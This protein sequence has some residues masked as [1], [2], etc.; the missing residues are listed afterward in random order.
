MENKG[1]K[2]LKKVLILG[3]VIAS[4]LSVCSCSENNKEE[5][6]ESLLQ[7]YK[8]DDFY[9][10]YKTPHYK[11]RLPMFWE[12]KFT[13]VSTKGREDFYYTN[14]YEQ[15]ESGL[16]FSI[17]EYK[18]KSYKKELKDYTYLCFDKRFNLHYCMTIPESSQC[19]EEFL[20]EFEQMKMG[21]PMVETTFLAEL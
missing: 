17:Y 12:N 14:A 16:L 7:H 21:V 18:D 19:P 15:D 10:D 6:S 11:F 9:F 2:I 8:N 5:I 4:L 3:V 13:V 20:E 1:L